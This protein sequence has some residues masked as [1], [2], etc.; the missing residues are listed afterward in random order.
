ML[1]TDNVARG[2]S[3]PWL[4]QR[5]H[6]MALVKT[7]IARMF[8]VLGATSLHGSR[9][10]FAA[11]A[12]G[13]RE[14]QSPMAASSPTAL[15]CE[16]SALVVKVAKSMNEVLLELASHRLPASKYCMLVLAEFISLVST[17]HSNSGAD[18]TLSPKP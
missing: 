8:L 12:S 4:S 9:G 1:A 13:Q 7:C 6:S 14:K 5:A 15:S 18:R 17:P 2:G 11:V 10:S 3:E 16:D